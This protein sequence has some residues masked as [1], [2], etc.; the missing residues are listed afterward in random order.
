M[1]KAQ[2]TTSLYN[3]T[4]TY[5]EDGLFDE[6]EAGEEEGEEV[7][8]GEVDVEGKVELIKELAVLLRFAEPGFIQEEDLVELVGAPPLV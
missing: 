7:E 4:L 3:G 1:V 2:S 5:I 6:L 8:E